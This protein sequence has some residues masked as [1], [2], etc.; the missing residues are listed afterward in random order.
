[1]LTGRS[2]TS[3]SSL[4]RNPD[5]PCYA[6]TFVRSG[7]GMI[8]LK[9]TDKATKALPVRLATRDYGIAYIQ[10]RNE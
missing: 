9:G 6:R 1:M 8:P 3:G 2:A 5:S 4:T 7:G 10:A